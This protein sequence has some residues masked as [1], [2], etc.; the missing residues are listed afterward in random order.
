EHLNTRTPEYPERSDMAHK[1][2]KE[3][4]QTTHNTARFFVE[5]RQI[6]W[7]L[8]IG[9]L[10]A[11][12]FGYLNM[13]KR[14]DPDIPVRVAVVVTPWLGATAEQVEQLVTR[15]IEAKVAQNATVYKL[16]TTSFPG[17]SIVQIELD[18]QTGDTAKQFDD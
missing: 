12:I 14:K 13:P 3:T 16:T 4:I 11:G 9:T 15:K 18:E 7:V 2:D 17:L 1:S 10:A 5:N 6:A 8:L